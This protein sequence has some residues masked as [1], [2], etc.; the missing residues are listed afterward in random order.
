MVDVIRALAMITFTPCGITLR[1]YR[2]A[3]RLDRRG[4]EISV[5]DANIHV[6]R[7]AVDVKFSCQSPL[8][9]SASLILGL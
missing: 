3:E 9:L 7:R 5:G 6:L 4:A 1:L 2:R 8:L